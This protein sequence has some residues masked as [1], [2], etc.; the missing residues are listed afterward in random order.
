MTVRDA[1]APPVAAV[2]ALV[3]ALAQPR[4]PRQPLKAKRA[5][6]AAVEVDRLAERRRKWIR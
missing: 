1:A 5:V 4:Q 3:R 2:R 6:G